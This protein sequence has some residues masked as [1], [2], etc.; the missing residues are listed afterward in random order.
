M[1]ATLVVGHLLGL[2]HR[3]ADYID[4]EPLLY[5]SMNVHLSLD[6]MNYG[7]RGFF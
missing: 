5:V 6:A 4:V 3:V 1:R 2:S 7:R